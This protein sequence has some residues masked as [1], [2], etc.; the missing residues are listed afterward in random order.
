MIAGARGYSGSVLAELLWRHPDVNLLC[1]TSRR[2]GETLLSEVSPGAPPL[3]LIHPDDLD[4]AGTDVAF[5]CLPAGEG[6]GLA[7]RF[8]D[9]GARVID[10]SGDHRIRDPRAHAETYPV[11]RSESLASSAV[12]GL[13]EL[14]RADLPSA[15]MVANPGCYPTA[16]LL[17]VAPIAEMG[18]LG[19]PILVD[20]KS[21]VSGAGRAP[22]ETTH[23]CSVHGDVGPYALGRSHRHVAEMEQCLADVSPSP[24]RSPQVVFNP[25]LVPLDR[26][27]L[28]TIVFESPELSAAQVWDRLAARYRRERFVK[29]LPPGQTARIRHAAGTNA[30]VISVHQAEGTRHV[31]LACAID[32]LLKGAAGQAVQNMN[33]ML[34]LPEERGLP[35]PAGDQEGIEQ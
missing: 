6:T 14:A 3:P 19:D 16:T 25:H 12:Y 15:R 1:G 9:R 4:F 27:L 20:A 31:V 10:L 21:G 34:G 32:N 13:T 35:L 8:Y 26:G 28:S 11:R 24:D 17:A 22:T 5:L 18:A 29:V 33:L 23:F 7:R 30:A 2:D